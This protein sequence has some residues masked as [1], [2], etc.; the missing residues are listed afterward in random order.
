MDVIEMFCNRLIRNKQVC[1]QNDKTILHFLPKASNIALY[2]FL[3]EHKNFAVVL[4]Y[5]ACNPSVANGFR[6]F[7]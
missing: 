5:D 2:Q 1:K 4:C 6:V 7:A 3:Y